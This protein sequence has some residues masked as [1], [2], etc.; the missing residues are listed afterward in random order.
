MSRLHFISI[1]ISLILVQSGCRKDLP[2]TIESE[3]VFNLDFSVDGVPKSWKAG[4]DN[5]YMSTGVDVIDL[6]SILLPVFTGTME[7]L[8]SNMESIEFRI[9]NRTGGIYSD[10]DIDEV[11]AKQDL[12]YFFP[13]NI[14]YQVSF[15]AMSPNTFSEYTWEFGDGTT[16]S[17]QVVQHFYSDTVVKK[18]N[19][20]LSVS[21]GA[22]CSKQYCSDIFMPGAFCTASISVFPDTISPL[23]NDVIYRAS[24]MGIP[25]FSYEWTFENGKKANT[26]E[27]RY[28]YDLTQ[29]LAEYARLRVTDR[30][31]CTSNVA[32]QL[33]IGPA[34]GNCYT[35]FTYGNPSLATGDDFGFNQVEIVYTNPEGVEYSSSHG[36]Q[37]G[38][39]FRVLSNSEYLTDVRGNRTRS[40]IVEFACNI[41]AEDSSSLEVEN[42]TGRIAVAY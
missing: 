26:Q 17:G 42:G 24:A 1:G 29:S 3:V 33:G 18:Y 38:S 21:D 30:Y 34:P 5:Y 27:V 6:D 13:E 2:A 39:Y 9:R 35:N 20:C 31:G 41:Y 28:A 7:E 15:T 23:T 11:L 12:E 4:V 32:L 40:L 14:G 19:V 36:I 16:G 22:G 10:G 8:V 25:P 37:S